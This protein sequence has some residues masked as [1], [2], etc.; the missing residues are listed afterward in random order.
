MAK[1]WTPGL[2][3][4]LETGRFFIRSLGRLDVDERF[5]GWL[6]DP[7]VMET[8]NNPA[9]GMTAEQLT[10]YIERFDNKAAFLLGVYCKETLL[11]VGFYAVTC[12]LP[13]RLAQTSVAIGDKSYWGKK[14]VLESRAAIIDFLF[15]EAG[16]EKVWG[17][18]FAR[19][20]PSVFNYRA[21]G[22]R[23]EGI[24]VKH[25]LGLKGERIDQ[26]VFGI[27]KEEW[28]ARKRPAA[29]QAAA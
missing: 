12:D 18:P 10:R 19:N 26:C 1:G 16:I 15:E 5:L 3:V 11:L 27:L 13:N 22:F 24:L 7:E 8:L 28:Q 21:Q 20:F 23:C 29:P 14:V 2:P 25:R 17:M 4:A 9:T 6:K